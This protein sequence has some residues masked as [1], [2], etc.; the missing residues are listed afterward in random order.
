MSSSRQLR[1]E[2]RRAIKIIKR[3]I[4]EYKATLDFL[5]EEWK[6]A[7]HNTVGN[8]VKI[9][10]KQIKECE[11][12]L[13][14]KLLIDAKNESFFTNK[15]A[16]SQAKVDAA[17]NTAETLRKQVEYARNCEQRLQNLQNDYNKQLD[18]NTSTTKQVNDLK[19]KMQEYSIRLKQL[20]EEQT[21]RQ[22]ERINKCKQELENKMKEV[23]ENQARMK[24]KYLQLQQTNEQLKLRVEEYK[25]QQQNT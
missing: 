9:L 2:Q 23:S 7:Q 10:N 8:Q 19:G 3:E 22:K 5:H 11:S 14:N 20:E 13:Q 4:Q 17:R 25:R 16:E 18:T 24:A 15:L 6:R 21:P 12:M 1:K